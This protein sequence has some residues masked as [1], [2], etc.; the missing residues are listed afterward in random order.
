MS[1][2]SLVKAEKTIK[3]K[4]LELR[5]GKEEL[6]RREYENFQ[7]YLRGDRSVPLYSATKQQAERLL[8]RLEGKLKLNREYPMILRRDV[9]RAGTKLTPYWLKIPI[10][11]VRGGI[12][13]PIK[14]HEPITEDMVCREAK[15]IRRKGEWFVYITVE[16]EVQ[17]RNLKSV[18]AVDLGIR[19]I[20]TTVNS[21]N[22]K[23]K[24]YGKELRQV[25]GHY[26]YLRR[27]LALK[28]AYKTIKKIG[29]KERRVVNDIL[30]K[31][32]RA[33]VNE[34]LEN[35]SMIVLGKLRGIRKN[36]KGR[37]FNRKLNNGFPYHRLSQFIEY[38]AK[39]VG[40][41]VIKVSEKNTSKTCHRCG[42]IGLRVGSLFKCPKCGYSCNADYNGATNILK[43]AMGYTPTA[44]APLTV[45]RTR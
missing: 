34:A 18:L 1:S 9:Y 25:K 23:P 11:G 21:N 31:I 44:G 19:W 40:I 14:T 8:R 3:A 2:E 35:D 32:S 13:V 4:I 37:K 42:S 24:F 20:A 22:P 6:L 39:W 38:K 36:G 41:K 27:S 10:Y 5:K 16:K 28:K 30:H 15:I 17:E 12:N 26:F 43:R 45:P 29:N 7:R 33:I